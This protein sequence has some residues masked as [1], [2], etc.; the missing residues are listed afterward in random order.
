MAMSFASAPWPH[1]V[2][3][4][5][6]NFSLLL[7]VGCDEQSLTIDEISEFPCFFIDVSE[8]HIEVKLY[9]IL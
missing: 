2:E 7:N 1:I 9:R 5:N 6:W 3:M 4:L 8:T